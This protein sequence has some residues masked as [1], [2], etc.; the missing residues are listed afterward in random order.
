MGRAIIWDFDGV[1]V[2]TPHEDA[3]RLACQKLGIKGFTKE[4]YADYVS[5]KPRQEGAVEILVRLGGYSRRFLLSTSEGRAVLERLMQEKNSIYNNLVEEGRYRLNDD[6]VKFMLNAKSQGIVQVLASA[7]KNASKLL[8]RITVEGKSLSKLL[9][10]DF[11]GLGETKR[12]VITRAV[13][14][15]EG[16]GIDRRC[17]LLIEDS[18]TGI[19][20]GQG[21][22]L[23]T[24]CYRCNGP[25]GIA[26]ITAEELAALDPQSVFKMLGC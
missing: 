2:L 14:H 9:D 10:Y 5:G 3:W 15:L 6:A 16:L 7:S 1:I 21:I 26:D 18:W 23:R 8:N 20:A 22:G 25:N 11:S 12:E 19:R 13:M 4:F 24:L 17:I